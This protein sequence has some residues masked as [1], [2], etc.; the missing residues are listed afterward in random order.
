MTPADIKAFHRI[1][2]GLDLGS[3]APNRESLATLDCPWLLRWPFRWLGSVSWSI[4]CL[5]SASLFCKEPVTVWHV[6]GIRDYWREIEATPQRHS[7][8]R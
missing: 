5:Q 6:L 3:P 1:V 4:A 8:Q 7:A 2:D